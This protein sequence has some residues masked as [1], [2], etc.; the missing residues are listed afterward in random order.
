MKTIKDV[1]CEICGGGGIC[2]DDH[3]MQDECKK[4][5]QALLALR[6]VVV[7]TE[8]ELEKKIRELGRYNEILGIYSFADIAEDGAVMCG[9]KQLAKAIQTELLHRL[10]GELK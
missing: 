3:K 5:N 1:I 10:N 9:I 2:P 6:E 7:P 8:D 4:L